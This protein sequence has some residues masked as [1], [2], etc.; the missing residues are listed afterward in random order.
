VTIQFGPFWFVACSGAHPIVCFVMLVLIFKLAGYLLASLL[1][2]FL[3][4]LVSVL[5]LFFFV[6][7]FI[8]F[9]FFVPVVPLLVLVLVMVLVLLLVLVLSVL[10]MLVLWR[11]VGAPRRR[12]GPHSPNVG[13]GIRNFCLV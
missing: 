11:G 13:T 10:L 3:K 2:F 1:E 6:L 4:V 5:G 8:V 7:S 9:G 12:A